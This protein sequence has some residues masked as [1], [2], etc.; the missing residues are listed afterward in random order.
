MSQELFYSFQTCRPFRA[1]RGLLPFFVFILFIG[2]SQSNAEEK[3]K[4]PRT[5]LDATSPF[6]KISVREMFERETTSIV[7]LSDPEEKRE[8]EK[9]AE[10]KDTFALEGSKSDGKNGGEVDLTPADRAALDDIKRSRNK[11]DIISPDENLP[12]RPS[13]D[14][15]GSIK[16]MSDALDNG[17]LETAHRYGEQFVRYLKDLTFKVQQMSQ[18]ILEAL[19]SQ[20]VVDEEDV[21]GADQLLNRQFADTRAREG[22]IIRPTHDDALTRIKP[23]PSGQANVFFFFSLNCSYC[24]YMAPDVERLWRVVKNDPKH[25]RMAALTIGPTPKAW[26]DSYKQYTGLTMPIAEGSEIA[27]KFNVRFVPSVVIVSPTNK[28]AYLK[29]GQQ[30]F[31]RLYEFLRTVQGRSTEITPELI[32]LVD[33]PIGEVELLRAKDIRI[34]KA[35][36]RQGKSRAT[37]TAHS[38]VT[39]AGSN[40]RARLNPKE[41]VGRF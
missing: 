35:A 30:D 18:I 26:S 31:Q 41:A 16:G 2:L 21:D 7:D 12:V 25:V 37:S 4:A 34:E 15:P 20:G 8:P 23:D 38:V 17:D 36:N 3:I 40:N 22:M 13:D 1:A 32:K 14:S 19:A 29:T 24:R 27:K 33:R 9:P 10:K 39:P 28:V 5:A 6:S 11:T